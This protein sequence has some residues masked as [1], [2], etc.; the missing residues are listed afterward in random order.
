MLTKAPEPFKSK[1]YEA[2]W[3]QATIKFKA[4]SSSKHVQFILLIS[5]KPQMMIFGG[6][7]PNRLPA[8]ALI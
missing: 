8:E 1:L 4:R 5:N 3:N 2:D 6:I 7:M